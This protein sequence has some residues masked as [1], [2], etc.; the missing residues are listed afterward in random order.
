MPRGTPVR[1]MDKHFDSRRASIARLQIARANNRLIDNRVRAEWDIDIILRD[2]VCS[3]VQIVLDQ[4]TDS[5]AGNTQASRS[6]QERV[7]F[8]NGGS[9]NLESAAHF[10]RS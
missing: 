8:E 5:S 6:M 1:A 10:R 7:A 9:E 3:G 4:A 2:L